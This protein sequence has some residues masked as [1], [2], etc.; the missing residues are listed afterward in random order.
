MRANSKKK[1]NKI[2][3]IAP[4]GIGENILQIPFLR[5]LKDIFPLAK[6]TLVIRFKGVI[7]LL[8]SLELVDDFIICDYAKQNTI[9]KKIKLISGIRKD[10]YDISFLA[11]PTSRLDKILF[12]EMCGAG[13][14]VG[15]Y[16]QGLNRLLALCNNI[17]I[18]VDTQLH[19]V[20]QNLNI[21]KSFCDDIEH[22][23][24]KIKLYPT[25]LAAE[26][27]EELLKRNMIVDKDVLIGIHSGSSKLFNMSY[28]RWPLEKYMELTS[29]LIEKEKVK[30]LNFK[31][32]EE[33]SLCM[34]EIKR[35]IINVETSL[36]VVLAL[37]TRCKLF[38]GND[39][40]L[41]HL[42]AASGIKV[43]GIF[44]PT[45]PKR[46]G[47][48]SNDSYVIKSKIDCSPCFTYKRLG[49]GITC[50]YRFRKC[51][52]SITVSEVLDKIGVML[53]S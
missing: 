31:T 45:N 27:A 9:V 35:N 4:T 2:L 18:K 43:V 32:N 53:S 26:K 34:D 16:P 6:V 51:L 38:I 10:K 11:F 12:S 36:D 25:K 48:Y 37:L 33:P 8:T 30:I 47:P 3:V 44:G 28:K 19:D 22:T 20:E 49:R 46:T 5:K 39:T 7:D 13:L 52:E 17:N 14:K 15:Y 41:M 24:K 1:I 50:P 29:R 23:D 21:L 42:A 40:A